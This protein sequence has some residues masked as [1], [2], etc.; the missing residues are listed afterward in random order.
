MKSFILITL[1]LCGCGFIVLSMLH[2]CRQNPFGIFTKMKAWPL[3]LK[4][5]YAAFSGVS[6][7]TIAAGGMTILADPILH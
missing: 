7:L 4:I 1:S 2:E 6:I 5:F 3:P